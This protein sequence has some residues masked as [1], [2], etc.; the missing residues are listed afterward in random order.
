MIRN[1]CVACGY[2]VSD[3][4]TIKTKEKKCT[5]CRNKGKEVIKTMYIC[6]RCGNSLGTK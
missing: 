6:P 4:S 1:S 3:I 2:I 5:S